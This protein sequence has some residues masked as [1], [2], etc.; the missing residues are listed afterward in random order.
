MNISSCG[1]KSRL[2]YN[3]KAFDTTVL[4]A[5]SISESRLLS[6][7]LSVGG[8]VEKDKMQNTLTTE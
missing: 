2:E 4:K 8:L 1:F 5:F 6:V 7:E 3:E